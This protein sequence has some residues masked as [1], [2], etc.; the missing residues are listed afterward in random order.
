MKKKIITSAL[1]AFGLIASTSAVFAA[2]SYSASGIYVP[3]YGGVWDSAQHP[4]SSSTQ[5]V[6]LV[7][8]TNNDTIYAEILDQQGNYLTTSQTKLLFG[9]DV[10]IKSGCSVGDYI[11]LELSTSLFNTESPQV[12]FSWTP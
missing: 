8:A 4:A 10:S 11:A 1:L 12:S 6:H 9:Q 3:R 5:I 2:Q 7:S